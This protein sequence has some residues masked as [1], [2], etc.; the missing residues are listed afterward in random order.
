MCAKIYRKF[1]ITVSKYK[2][3]ET[4]RDLIMKELKLT[5]ELDHPNIYKVHESFEDEFKIYF[6]IDE[7]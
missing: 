4:G 3:G 7:F 5:A 6:V 1:D 2:G